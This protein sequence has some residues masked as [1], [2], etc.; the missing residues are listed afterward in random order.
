MKLSIVIPSFYP[1]TVYGGPIFSSLH[2]SQELAKLDDIEVFVSTTNANMT[3]YLN[4]EINKWIQFQDNLQVKYYHDTKINVISIGLLFNLW[5][6][7]KNSDIV[8]V[9]YIF[10][11]TT[12]IALI[13]ASLFKKP[14]ILS[15]RGALC[16]WCLEQGNSFK[17]YWLRYLINPFINKILWHATAEEE[18]NEILAQF[19]HADVEI[20]PNG[21]EYD[22]FQNYSKINAKEFCK[23]YA[24]EELEVD[25]IIVSMG[26]LQKKKGFDILINSFVDVRKTYPYAKLFI[27]GQD[28]GEKENLLKQISNLQLEKSVFL[29]GQVEGN[30]KINFLANADLFVL[31]SHGENFGNVYLESL[32]TGTP[33]VAS[34]STPWHKVEEFECGKWVENSVSSTS[35]AMI[36]LL[37]QNQHELRTNAKKLARIYEWKNVAMQFKCIFKNLSKSYPIHH[38][39]FDK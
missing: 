1:A 4:V 10:N 23:L 3:S 13:Y 32:A 31:S 16:P 37:K 38:N 35:K 6:D 8:H 25:K 14:L 2:T 34:K 27:A 36:E 22:V 21:I 9:Q 18:K 30:H 12:I 5:K 17:K 39:S 7:I 26:R 20:V 33:I 15:A 28:E 29:V 11:S 19:P 24:N